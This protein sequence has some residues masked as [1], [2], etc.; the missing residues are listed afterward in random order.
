MMSKNC[1]AL[2]ILAFSISP[3]AVVRGDDK[4]PEPAMGCS[5]GGVADDFFRN[6]VWAKVGATAC[7]QCHKAGGDAEESKF[8]LLDPRKSSGQA[9]DD[10]FKQNR[11]AFAK[12]AKLI[13]V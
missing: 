9:Q 5:A 13:P 6:E 11:E 3:S 7:L 1:S 8:I 4:K 2:L 10:A 12:M